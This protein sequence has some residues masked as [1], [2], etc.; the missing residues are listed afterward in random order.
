MWLN[1]PGARA[2][3]ETADA[4][5]RYLEEAG[6]A[7]EAVA[8]VQRD[9]LDRLWDR[10]RHVPYYT[11]LP[12]VAERDLARLPVTGKDVLKARPADFVRADLPPI[13]KYYESSG[14]SGRPTPTPRL[15]ED[16]ITN[17]IG[18][19]ALWRRALGDEPSRVA[20]LL[21]SDVVPVCDFVAA[22]C[23]YLGHALLRCYPFSLGICD[24]DRLE[25]L[26]A[27]YRP[28]R[29]FAAPGVLAQWT[30]ILKSRGTLAETRA[31]VR[32]VLLLGEVSLPGQR[33]RLARDWGADVLDASYGSTETGTIAAT[34]DRGSLHL[35]PHG[36]LLEL[37][38]ADGAVRPLAPGGAGELVDTTLNNYARPLLRFGTGDRV[39]LPAQPCACGLPLPTLRVHGRGAE[40]VPV[41]AAELTEHLVGS[42]VYDDPRLTGY[43]IQLRDDRARLVVERD[44]DVEAPD[45]EL[46][47]AVARRFAAA[48][49]VFD[50]V[51]VVGQLPATSKSGGSQKNWKRTNV[52][53]VR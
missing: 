41:G 24:W 18:V 21:P 40:R 28:E 51:V 37:R 25:A 33:R 30:R 31:S 5:V 9:K 45:A 7:P 27:G 50:D 17:V 42:V 53:T 14:S 44:V 32:T 3:F 43:L 4:E 13:A 26:F 6:F 15:A 47:T 20:A 8:R 29:V 34:C 52:V 39:D 12:G 11:G 35:L 36:H 19:S 48:G 38:G 1:D 46:T 22:T 16:T 10:A 49:V 23:E 2:A